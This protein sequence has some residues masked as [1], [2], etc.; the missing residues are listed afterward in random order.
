MRKAQK[1]DIVRFHFTGCLENG[2]RFATT[3]GEDPMELT[4]GE[5]K[6]IRCFETSLV[7]MTEGEQRTVHI[8]PEDAMG[9]RQPELVSELPLHM[10]PEQDEDL[11]V[12]SSIQIK[13]EKGREVKA[14]VTHL[15]DQAVTI[16]S[17]HP[18]AGETLVFDINLIEFV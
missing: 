18:L 10:I 4:I 8:P 13:D 2:N 7:G 17:N 1:G 9:A 5:G 3:V 15:S 16:D 12:G 11:K 6:L 14:T